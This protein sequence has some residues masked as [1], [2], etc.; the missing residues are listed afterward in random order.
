MGQS[1]FFNKV[2]GL[3][4]AILFKKSLAQVLSCRFLQNFKN[5]FFTEHFRATVSVFR[6]TIELHN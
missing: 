4:T 6:T 3:R 1:L 5:T 2:A